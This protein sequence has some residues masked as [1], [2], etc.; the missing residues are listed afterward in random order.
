[1]H[2]MGDKTYVASAFRAPWLGDRSALT[3]VEWGERVF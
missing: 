1:V 2:G 3:G